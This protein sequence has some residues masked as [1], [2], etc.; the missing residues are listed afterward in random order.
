MRN[1][2]CVGAALLGLAV[3]PLQAAEDRDARVER[4]ERT[5]QDL[6]KALQRMQAE[7]GELRNQ[8]PAKPQELP[9]Q[10]SPDDGKFDP[11]GRERYL[12]AA[13]DFFGKRVGG[14][15]EIG[16]VGDVVGRLSKDG[17]RG[18][19]RPADGFTFR[20]AELVFGAHIDPYSRGDLV[21]AFPDGETPELEEGY[22][23]W[24]ALPG[25]IDKLQVGK[26]R[27][28]FGKL[29]RI[30]TDGLPQVD[31]PRVITHFFGAEG[32]SDTGASVTHIIDNP[33]DVFSQV[34]YTLGNGEN[35]TAFDGK[36]QK[37]PMHLLHWTN[38]FELSRSSGLELGLSGASGA[39]D[40][41]ERNAARYGG[42][43]LTYVWKRDKTESFRFQNELFWLKRQRFTTDLDV[44]DINIGHTDERKFGMYSFVEYQWAQRWAGGARY[45]YAQIPGSTVDKDKEWAV[46][47][48]LTFYQS[49]FHR[50]RLELSHRERTGNH[51]I[52]GYFRNRDSNSIA[53]QGTFIL[54]THRPHPY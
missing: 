19:G 10:P 54:G 43:D 21:L 51:S 29:N 4:L 9:A 1:G 47:P 32:L 53:L 31:Y 35:T 37:E 38:F 13:S 15:L 12:G 42:L 39:Q 17:P 27:S 40:R 6:Q 33:W 52:D 26:V 46:S 23:T 16:V 49:E 20:E 2:V 45:D 48:Y 41:R 18:S 50:L 34:S 25:G 36:N 44:T 8:E 7:L 11:A 3:M 22:V 5:V 28:H 24:L 30:H 14:F